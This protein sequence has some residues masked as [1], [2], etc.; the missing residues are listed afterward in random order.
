MTM[1]LGVK[2]IGFATSPRTLK[3]GASSTAHLGSRFLVD[4]GLGGLE[5]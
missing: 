1:W 4:I 5:I 2:K 3:I